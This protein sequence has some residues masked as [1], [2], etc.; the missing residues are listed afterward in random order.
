M[1][2]L[3]QKPTL[4]CSISAYSRNII[5]H[6]FEVDFELFA[7]KFHCKSQFLIIKVVIVDISTKNCKYLLLCLRTHHPIHILIFVPVHLVKHV[8]QILTEVKY[9]SEKTSFRTWS[10]IISFSRTTLTAQPASWISAMIS[11][12]SSISTCSTWRSLSR[13]FK[14]F[15]KPAL[16]S[17]KV[18]QN[19]QDYQRF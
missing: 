15:S 14:I 18:A 11:R 8:L 7:E 4:S 1:I 12:N 5:P 13:T 9:V 17:F 16:Y 10:D 2:I 6:P 19:D 3:R